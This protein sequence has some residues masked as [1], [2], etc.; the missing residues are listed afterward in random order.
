MCVYVH[1]EEAEATSLHHILPCPAERRLKGQRRQK[2]TAA[3][4]RLR[5][6][7]LR[8]PSLSYR[9]VERKWLAGWASVPIP[10]VK[11]LDGWM[12]GWLPAPKIDLDQIEIEIE[13]D[14]GLT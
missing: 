6:Y 13:I 12:A 8:P 9:I 11:W 10:H 3:K 2:E 1:A 4:S 5:R 14:L 7:H